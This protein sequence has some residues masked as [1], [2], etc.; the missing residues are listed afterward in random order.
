MI[1]VLA[2]NLRLVT[3]LPEL[4]PALEG[5]GRK[6]DTARQQT[7]VPMLQG[8]LSLGTLAIGVSQEQQDSL[9]A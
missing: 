8:F 4:V 3:R 1:V 5:R 6:P 7:H 9:H 2:R